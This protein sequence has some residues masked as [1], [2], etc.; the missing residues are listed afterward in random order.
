VQLRKI[1]FT[2]YATYL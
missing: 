2:S 1:L